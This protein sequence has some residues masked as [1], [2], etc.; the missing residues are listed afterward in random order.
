MHEI[1][2]ANSVV[3]ICEARAAGRRVRDVVLEVGELSGVVPESIEFCF[4][5]CCKGTALEGARLR[6]DLV[7]GVA[8]CPSCNRRMQ[9][10]TLFS[11]CTECGNFGMTIV[12]GRD[13]RVREIEL[14]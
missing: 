1:S 12:S 8:E 5:A 4:E 6:L 2:I 11:P 3:E 13:L 9:V 14:E 7:P 10:D